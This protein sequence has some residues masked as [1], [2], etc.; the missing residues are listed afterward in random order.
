LDFGFQI[1]RRIS[2]DEA[3]MKKRS[4]GFWNLDQKTI[5]NLQ[6]RREIRINE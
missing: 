2:M 5:L 3:Q 1:L 6:S 4:N